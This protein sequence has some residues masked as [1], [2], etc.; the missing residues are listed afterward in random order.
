MT[1]VIESLFLWNYMA[2]RA[3][4][5][6][7]ISKPGN[8]HRKEMQVLELLAFLPLSN[9]FLS[10]PPCPFLLFTIL[11]SPFVDGRTGGQGDTRTYRQ[12][13]TDGH[14]RTGGRT[15]GTQF[16]RCI[17]YTEEKKGQTRTHTDRNLILLLY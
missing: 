14:I 1:L 10:L 13:R 6:F 9:T 8:P 7:I 4:L 3:L 11:S 16:L 2:L 5:Q 17:P 15:D 12:I